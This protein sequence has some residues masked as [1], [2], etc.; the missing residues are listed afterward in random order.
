MFHTVQLKPQSRDTSL[1]GT[2]RVTSDLDELST[3]T[4]LLVSLSQKL[5]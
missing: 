1:Q 2:L 3:A 4:R 5:L